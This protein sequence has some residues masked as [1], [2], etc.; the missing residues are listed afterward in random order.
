[1]FDNDDAVIRDRLSSKSKS[2]SFTKSS[3]KSGATNKDLTT[4]YSF[5]VAKSM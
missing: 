2:H 1:M 4:L 3:L 5:L